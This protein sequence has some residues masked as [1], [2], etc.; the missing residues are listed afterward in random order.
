MEPDRLL[1]CISA[2]FPLLHF[3]LP[4]GKFVLG[5]SSKSTLI[6]KDPSVSRRHAEFV[7]SPDGVTVR[8]LNSRNG[9]YL[10]ELRIQSSS[11]DLGDRLRFGNVSF[12][13]TTNAGIEREPDSEE[14]T[15]SISL[16]EAVARGLVNAEALTPA[17]RRVLDLV[18]EGLSQKRIAGRLKLSTHTVHNHIRAIYQIFEVHSRAE[19]LAKLLNERRD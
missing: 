19:L 1:M 13:L 14:R 5:R 17:Q 7:V 10:D 9:S 11:V 12:L 8:D 2:E 18:T 16:E 6:V 4:E 3:V 15:D